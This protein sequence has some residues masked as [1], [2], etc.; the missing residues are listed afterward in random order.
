MSKTIKEIY[1]QYESLRKTLRLIEEKRSEIKAFFDAADPDTL[2]AVGC[3]SSFQLSESIAMSS[4]L[5][6]GIPG[7]ALPGGDLMI[8]MDEYAP[9][10]SG[11]PVVVTISRS[12]STS[13]VLYSIRELKKRYPNMKSV[14][15]AC[16]V[17]SVIAKES[18]LVIEIPWAFDESVCQ[19]RSVTN[20]YSAAILM[21]AAA[22]DDDE[23][24]E[25]YRVLADNGDD[26]IDKYDE[27]LKT[28]A[29]TDFSSAAVL[30]DGQGFG[31]A[32]EAA[33]AFN[34]ICYTPSTFKHV[35][36]VR[37]GPIV[38]FNK[39]TLVIIKV[40]KADFDRQ[41]AL[42]GDVLK[43]GANVVTVSDEVLP[44]IDGVAAQICFG[45]KMADTVSALL[46]LPV[47]QLISFYHALSVGAD[48][49]QPDGLDAWIKL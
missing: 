15:I 25:S 20:L 7:V 13:E 35:L 46:L 10:F 18:D 27:V 12:G 1:A 40:K 24:F 26:Y 5:I 21:L 6:A 11:S 3:G 4:R 37:H 17:D 33:L 23:T 19:T 31:V 45:Q 9:V 47:A 16:T 34:E 22:A 28:I 44:K 39:K 48:P 42:I 29:G 30:C 43:R 8:G 41:V 32:S 49:D 2:V 36:D 14:C 38:L